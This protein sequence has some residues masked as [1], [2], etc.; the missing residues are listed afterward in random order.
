[1]IGGWPNIPRVLFFSSSSSVNCCF[2]SSSQGKAEILSSRTYQRKII[3]TKFSFL[4]NCIVFNINN[5][6]SQINH[7]FYSIKIAQGCALAVPST[8]L[9]PNFCSQKVEDLRFL[10]ETYAGHPGCTGLPS[11]FLRAQC[12]M[13]MAIL[14]L[15]TFSEM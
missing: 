13:L 6:L 2:L 10:L 12:F 4:I 15:P 3:Q 7:H 11:I 14:Y 1:M 5:F 8:P 9:V